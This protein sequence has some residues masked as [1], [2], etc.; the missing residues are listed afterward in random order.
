MDRTKFLHLRVNFRHPPKVF[1]LHGELPA[2]RPGPNIPGSQV[3]HDNG[4]AVLFERSLFIENA[5]VGHAVDQRASEA[6]PPRNDQVVEI[7]VD[8]A[9]CPRHVG[10]GLSVFAAQQGL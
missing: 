5:V 2:R 6:R 4:E 10:H 9:T 1:R 8:R 7:D 3:F